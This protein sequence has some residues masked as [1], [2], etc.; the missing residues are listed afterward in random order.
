MS[1]GKSRLF[2]SFSGQLV[3]RFSDW[4]LGISALKAL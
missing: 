2:N 1:G 4:G 3:P